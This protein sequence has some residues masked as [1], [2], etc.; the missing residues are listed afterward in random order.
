MAKLRGHDPTMV[1]PKK[2]K[3]LIFGKPGVGK[4]WVS[5]DFPSVYYIDVEQ[6]A[7]R[8]HYTA[9]LQES[10]AAYF[11]S[12]D[13]DEV[14]SE[15]ATLASGGHKYKTLVI[16][17][18]SKLYNIARAYAEEHGGSEFGRD[19]KEANRPTRRLIGWLDKI[20]MNVVLICH[21]HPVW[22]QKEVVGATFDGYDKLAYELDLLLQ[23][24]RRGTKRVAIV[25]KSRLQGFPDGATFDWSYDEF[26]VRYGRDI[27]ESAVEPVE[28]AT[29]EQINRL[30]ALIATV[31]VESDTVDRWLSKAKCETFEKMAAPD[32]QKCID[33]LA[34]KANAATAA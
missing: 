6:G 5:L 18:F 21:E 11:Y 10:K 33:Y 2:A 1:R 28:L 4:T 20:D 7:T 25:A 16:D 24:Q 29:A 34:K 30:G 14:I 15:I 19:K 22:E 32:I 26:A 3:V 8:E 9:K 31:K 17:S 13:F 27:M 12:Q 23:I